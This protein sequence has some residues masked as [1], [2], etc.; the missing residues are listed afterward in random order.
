M[1]IAFA[2]IALIAG[3]RTIPFVM[4]QIFISAHFLNYRLFEEASFFGIP[5]NTFYPRL[6]D[7]LLYTGMGMLLILPIVAHVDANKLRWYY[8]W[9][10]FN[11]F[12]NFKSPPRSDAE[13]PLHSVVENSPLSVAENHHAAM[14]RTHYT[15]MPRAHHATTAVTSIC[16]KR[17]RLR[18]TSP[19]ASYLLS[20]RIAGNCLRLQH[21][22]ATKLK[23][24]LRWA[25]RTG[26]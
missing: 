15:A 24:I 2:L 6:W 1:G 5:I 23:T 22:P 18:L 19:L 21:N 20:V 16:Q 4:L 8:Q 7:S 17:V 25:E 13:N 12:Q 3:G 26:M 9:R 10:L 14:P 11:A